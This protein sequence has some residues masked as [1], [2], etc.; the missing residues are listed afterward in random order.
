M[1]R[2]NTTAATIITGNVPNIQRVNS[3]EKYARAT[4]PPTMRISPRNTSA[5]VTEM[6]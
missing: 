3:T 5:R 1:K 4:M 2:P 6:S